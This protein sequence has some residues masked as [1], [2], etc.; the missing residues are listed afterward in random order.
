MTGPCFLNECSRPSFTIPFLSKRS[1]ELFLKPQ[2]NGRRTLLRARFRF[3]VRQVFALNP[4]MS[5]NVFEELSLSL[6]GFGGSG[7]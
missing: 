1:P 3:M 7:V 2:E 4:L 6:G 5:A